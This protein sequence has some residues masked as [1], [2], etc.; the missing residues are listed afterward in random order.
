MGD[1]DAVFLPSRLAKMLQSQMVP[2][3]GIY[4]ENCKYVDYGYFGN[5][6]VFSQAAFATLLQNIDT[7]NVSPELNWEVG[8]KNGKYGPMGE[9]LFAQT[10]MDRHWVKK[11]ERFDLTR[12]G[13][14]P[15]DRPKAEKNNK[16]YVPSCK[17]AATVTIHP[18]KKPDKY[19]E[20]MEEA[21]QVFPAPR[22]D[23]R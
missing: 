20:C 15:A 1:V 6:E 7:C 5:L 19:F 4:L 17:G 13:T 23:A 18:Y 12:A 9:D 11:V 3:N 22:H 10:C 8:I 2:S 14:C 16:K 21:D